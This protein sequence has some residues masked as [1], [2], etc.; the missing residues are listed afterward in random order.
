MEE[1]WHSKHGFVCARCFTDYAI[2]EFIEGSATEN[3]CSYC[4]RQED[5]PIAAELDEVMSFI[6]K[7]IWREYDIPENCLPYDS[8]EGGWQLAT[9]IDSHDLFEALDICGADSGTLYEDLV[10]GFS[11]TYVVQRDP[12][13]LSRIDG[14]K[15]SWA[16]FCEHTKHET[17]FVFF[18]VPPPKP[19]DD[20]PW[21]PDD[22][23]S[24]EYSPPYQILLDLGKMVE[25]HQLIR[26]VRTGTRFIRVRQHR[27]EFAYATAHD[28]GSPPR[29]KARQSRM[30]PAGIPMFYGA[31]DEST[32]F[33]EIFESAAP[34]RSIATF[35]TFV[36]TRDMLLLDLTQL[37]RV[38]SV[39][40][41]DHFQER[42]DVMFLHHVQQDMAAAITRD[43]REHYEY[44]PTQ[45][46]AEYFRRVFRHDERPLDGLMFNSSH[47]GAGTCYC[48]FA[49]AEQCVETSTDHPKALLRL[50]SSRRAEIDFGTHS[51]V[52]APVI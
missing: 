8:S 4:G 18:R 49:T 23:W 42:P 32:A 34:D 50:E 9:P 40:D 44:I 19:L 43:G 47:K 38:P 33:I 16:S 36:T 41:E 24:G 13:V 22:E 52:G 48:I 11:D 5:E 10:D 45:I 26:T 46:V 1:G 30:S 17:R 37:P 3:E 29:E 20:H 6:S 28:L 35:G 21:H 7:G 25:E 27:P 15:Y 2:Q 12:L 51:F 14:L 31:S 39:F